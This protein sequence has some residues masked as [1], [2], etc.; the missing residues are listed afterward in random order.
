MTSVP[1]LAYT[2]PISSPITPPPTTTIVF[3]TFLRS[4]APVDVTTYYSS[5]SRRPAGSEA[6]SLPVAI[7][8]LSAVI[9]YDPPSLRSIA[10]SFVELNLPHPLI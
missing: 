6:G 5:I 8:V 2:D 7:I 9:T 4:R 10:I 3:G 1:S